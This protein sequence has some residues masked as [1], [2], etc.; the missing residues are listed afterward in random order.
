MKNAEEKQKF[1]SIFSS[2]T[3]AER[4]GNF[5]QYWD[6]IQNHCGQINEAEK[7]LK[8]KQARLEQFQA[9]KIRS[10]RPLP[11]PDLFYRNYVDLK[12]DPKL[13]DQKTLLLTCIYKFARHEWVGIS[14]AWDLIPSLADSTHTVEKI[15]RYHLC[16]EFSHVRFFH[17]MFRTVHLN[18]VEWVPLGAITQKLYRIF[19]IL[20]NWFMQPLS[21]VTELMGITFYIHINRLL[22][23]IFEDE[24]KARDRIRELLF[25]IMIDETAHIGLRRNFLRPMGISMAKKMVTPMFRAFFRDIPESKH[26]LD[27]NQMIQDGLNFDYSILPSSLSGKSWVP[28]YLHQ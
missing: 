9:N 2:N 11:N 12:E 24:P 5:D 4:V 14:A 28:T 18:E 21:F 7:K 8:K 22:D 20:P 23:S 3:P 19:I 25:E 16:E 1:H 10:Q 13:F 27:I 15:N 17:E 26:L 6:Y